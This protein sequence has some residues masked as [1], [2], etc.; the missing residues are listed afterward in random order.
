M[1]VD[2]DVSYCSGEMEELSEFQALKYKEANSSLHLVEKTKHVERMFVN[3]SIT[4]NE[5]GSL[6]S[7][8][9]VPAVNA[10]AAHEFKATT[11]ASSSLKRTV[12][13]S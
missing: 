2:G 3:G 1:S 12:T 7:M 11:E 6:N 4:E 9:V 13:P 5:G 8:E 10:A